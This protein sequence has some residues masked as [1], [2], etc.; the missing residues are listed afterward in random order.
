MATNLFSNIVEEYWEE[1]KDEHSI[2]FEEFKKVCRNIFIFIKQT[3]SSGV[4]KN[5][6]VKYLGVFEVSKSRVKYCKKALKDNLE[7][8]AISEEW[9]NK[10]MKIL[11]NYD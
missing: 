11:S 3:I 7:K 8:G 10:R 9:F 1:V 5:I 6:R 2:S 4:G